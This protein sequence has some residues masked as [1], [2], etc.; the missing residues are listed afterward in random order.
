MTSVW[1]QI[2]KRLGLVDKFNPRMKDVAWEEWDAAV[3]AIYREGYERWA[4]SPEIAPLEPP[5][6]HS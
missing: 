2:A 3:E 4:A 1:T 5:D 6:I